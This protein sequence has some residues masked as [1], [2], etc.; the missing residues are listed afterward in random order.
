MLNPNINQFYF[1]YYKQDQLFT[2]ISLNG[3]L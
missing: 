1:K 2:F 3:K